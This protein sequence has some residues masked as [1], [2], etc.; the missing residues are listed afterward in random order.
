MEKLLIVKFCSFLNF[1]KNIVSLVVV[2]LL[3]G[4]K[5]ILD[6]IQIANVFT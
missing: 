3:L 6:N 4:R 1:K 2:K 5:N